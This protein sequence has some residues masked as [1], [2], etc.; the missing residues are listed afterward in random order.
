VKY[1]MDRMGY[2][3]QEKC[4]NCDWEGFRS[5]LEKDFVFEDDLEDSEPID[6]HWVCPNCRQ[7]II[8]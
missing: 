4:N 5:E 7:I 1:G 8:D 2:Y 6:E 3:E